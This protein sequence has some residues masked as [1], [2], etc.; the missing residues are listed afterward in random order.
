MYGRS[1]ARFRAGRVRGRASPTGRA[2]AVICRFV[3][4]RRSYRAARGAADRIGW[5]RIAPA[6]FRA[7]GTDGARSRLSRLREIPPFAGSR[8]DVDAHLVAGRRVDEPLVG[9]PEAR[10]H[11]ALGL[12]AAG[13]DGLERPVGL[14]GPIAL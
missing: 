7:I 14:V 11:L 3:L 1:G 5:P 12:A 4:L 10:L 8:V 13:S 2:T 6:R 9:R